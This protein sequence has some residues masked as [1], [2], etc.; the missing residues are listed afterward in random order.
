[1]VA[2]RC[3]KRLLR[4]RSK[5]RWRTRPWCKGSLSFGRLL[6]DARPGAT[7]VELIDSADQI[8]RF[9]PAFHQIVD[10]GLVTF[11]RVAA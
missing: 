5:K 2:T 3:T 7:N 1:M 11:K 10:S 8:N 4:G 6:V 9:L